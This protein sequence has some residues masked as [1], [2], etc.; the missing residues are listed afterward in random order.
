MGSHVSDGYKEPSAVDLG[1]CKAEKKK[2]ETRDR[3]ILERNLQPV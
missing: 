2:Q 1:P 3:L